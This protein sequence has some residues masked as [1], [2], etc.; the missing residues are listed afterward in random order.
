MNFETGHHEYKRQLSRD[1]KFERAVVAF[2][3]SRDGGAIFVGIEDDGAVCGVPN[4]DLVQRQI[5]DRIRNNIRP[6]TMGLFDIGIE[7]R[8]GKPVVRVIVSSGPD[9]PYYIKQFG[10]TPTEYRASQDQM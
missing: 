8:D 6:A 3:N 10:M 5:A 1:D 9:R 7:E 2:L 4:P